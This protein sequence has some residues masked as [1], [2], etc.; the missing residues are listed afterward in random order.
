MSTEP[1][2]WTVKDCADAWEITPATWRKYVSDDRAPQPLPGYD[3]QR[4]RRWD[5]E[6]V[7]SFP[8]PG[9]GA[10]TDVTAQR[11][12]ELMALARTLA[13]AVGRYDE[14]S[15]LDEQV[16]AGNPAAVRTVVQRAQAWARRRA[17][18]D[19]G[20]IDDLVKIEELAGQIGDLGSTVLPMRMREQIAIAEAKARAGEDQSPATS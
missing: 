6:T 20:P 15:K 9:R 1:E 14:W 2:T 5:P 11:I 10:R 19:K 8:R 18:S 13:E 17:R 7:R 4:Q 12:G 16:M 3:E